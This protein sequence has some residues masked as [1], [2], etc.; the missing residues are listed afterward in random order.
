MPKK[1]LIVD[2]D[3]F[4][5]EFLCE[6]LEKRGYLVIKA[7]DG[8]EGISKLEEAPADI[9]FTDLLMP[10]MDVRHFIQFIRMKYQ[11]R[12]L[13]IVALSGAVIEQL[14][15]LDK[16]GADYYIPKGPIDKLTV[17]INEFMAEIETQ[18]FFPSEKKKLLGNAN[19]FPR[20]EA[21]ELINSLQ[22][23]RAVLENLGV[24][25]IIVDRD[26]RVLNANPMALDI[27]G[28]SAVEVLNRPV[29]ELFPG[30]IKAELKEA[31]K[32]VLQEPEA[33]RKPFYTPF[34]R[35]IIRT[36]VSP[37]LLDDTIAGWV[38]ALDD[39]DQRAP[40]AKCLQAEHC[41]QE[42]T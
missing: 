6:L 4:F 42:A 15:T 22:F 29:S 26:T 27:V 2:H 30:M 20:R 10:K 13:P 21:V 11:N 39:C 14:G 31:L 35:H 1:V 40:S 12:Y 8:K 25:V 33:K 18:A 37:I 36:I 28:K 38:I 17:Q 23:H 32:R 34:N 7:Y 19:I 41:V 16:I 5:V 9:I 3:Y 24:G